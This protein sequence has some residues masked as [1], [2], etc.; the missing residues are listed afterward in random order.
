MK[1]KE[2]ISDKEYIQN[3]SNAINNYSKTVKFYS[4]NIK[5]IEGIKKIIYEYKE[6]ISSFQKKLTHIR[7][8]L[9]KPLYQEE[10]KNFSFSIYNKYILYI[11]KFFNFQIESMTNIIQEINKKIIEEQGNNKNENLNIFNQNK[12]NLQDKQIKMEKIFI[13]YDSE[14]KNYKSGLKSIE[15]D[16]QN[17]YYNLRRKTLK[18][19]NI[20]FNKILK[21]ANNIHD[22]FIKIHKKFGENNNKY[23]EY[24][25]I[26]MKEIEKLLI[27]KE[28]YIENNIN[29]F[30]LILQEQI[31]ST[32]NTLKIFYS[33]ENKEINKEKNKDFK[34]FSENNLV[35]LVTK[36]EKKKY[37]LKSLKE[38][39]V[40]NYISKENKN[41]L[42]YLSDELGFENFLDAS[43]INLNE[44]DIFD[45]VKFF[46][47]VFTYIDT[48]E[49]DLNLEKIKFNIRKFTNKLLL[50][51]LIK[52]EPKEFN[53]LTPI[54]DE[55]IN[56]LQNYLPKNRIYIMTFL[57]RINNFRTLG[58]F[59]IPERE[60]EIIGNI[61]KLILDCISKEKTQE[62][63]S[64]IKL[65]IILSQTFYIN[66]EGKKNY[67]SERLK[68]NKF[69]SET[70]SFTDYIR[71]C[72]KKELEKSNSKTKGKISENHKKEMIFATIL[73]FCNYLKEM[74]ISKEQLIKM[75]QNLSKEYELNEEFV[76]IINQS[77]EA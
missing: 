71:S 54:N 72:I 50:F 11:D 37:K 69:F 8:N 17:Y 52:K 74:D 10:Q 5:I 36:Y 26:I 20:K 9:I 31:N 75:V 62:D 16:V 56:I 77:I 73:P 55:E 60:Y 76:N 47:G 33:E 15:E 66:K 63:Y 19:P 65:L 51:G 45:V 7:K 40:T 59:E 43:A 29:S 64:I 6:S 27:D 4:N 61:F 14:Y 58:I 35:K 13:E 25:D 1:D 30:I 48:S 18:D 2:H 24:Y 44:D 39:P 38:K 57:Q 32:I 28:N 68:G 70:E 23:F 46:N 41:V 67:I 22:S 3:Y 34:I 53:D 42:K 12:S 49:Y 21:E